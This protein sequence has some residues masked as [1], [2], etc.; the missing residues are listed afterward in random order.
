VARRLQRSR[1]AQ[2]VPEETVAAYTAARAFLMGE[3]FGASL[4]VASI[5]LL[6]AFAG[7]AP[8]VPAS[9][10]IGSSLALLALGAFAYLRNRAYYERL[11]FPWARRWHNAALVVAGTGA[12]FWL[13]FGLLVLLASRGFEVIPAP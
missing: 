5:T 12:I 1:A 10:A 9:W 6:Y 3:W 13:L 7:A 4:S 8:E 11:G 2:S